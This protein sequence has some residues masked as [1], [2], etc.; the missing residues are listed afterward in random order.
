RELIRFPSVNPPGDELPVARYIA[1]E[2]E[3]AGVEVKLLEP[4]R[5]RGIVVGT[6]RGTGAKP[7]V[8]L[9][10]HTDVVPA[11]GQPWSV[12]PFG[13]EV[14]DGYVY[15]R[16]AFD[17]KGMVAVHLVCMLLLSRYVS[18]GGK[19]DCDVG[20]LANVDEESGGAEGMWW[21]LTEHPELVTHAACAFNEGGRLCV[22]DG[23]LAFAAI[24]TAE[25]VQH[26]V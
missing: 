20:M 23:K 12:D 24:Q 6:L 3:R 19:L 13:G 15:G 1:S 22:V 25:K 18:D 5:D 7:P 26:V 21:L 17:D 4:A 14:H 9:V 8:L 2:L 16:G 10:S 11:A